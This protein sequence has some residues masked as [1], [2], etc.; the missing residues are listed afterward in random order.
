MYIG[1]VAL[2]GVMTFMGFVIHDICCLW[3]LLPDDVCHLW[4][5]S[6]YEDCCLVAL[7]CCHLYV[8]FVTLLSFMTI[9]EFVG[10]YWLGNLI[11]AGVLNEILL[12]TLAGEFLNL[13]LLLTGNFR[14][15]KFKIITISYEKV[16]IHYFFVLKSDKSLLISKVK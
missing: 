10:S 14:N 2:L 5:L 12:F 7:W 8:G 3:G 13:L 11:F 1:F 6:P 9:I 4:D 15:K 16:K